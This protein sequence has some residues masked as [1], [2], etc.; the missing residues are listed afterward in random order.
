MGGQFSHGFGRL[1][2]RTGGRLS[3]ERCSNRP[4]QTCSPVLLPT[5]ANLREEGSWL[6]QLSTMRGGDGSS[7]PQFSRMLSY[8]WSSSVARPGAWSPSASMRQPGAVGRSL[9]R[10]ANRETLRHL[11]RRPVG[12][13]RTAVLRT[14]RSH[15]GS[16]VDGDPVRAS[17]LSGLRGARLRSVLVGGGWVVSR[18]WSRDRHPGRRTPGAT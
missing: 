12:G 18:M 2:P 16:G 7:Y 4:W 3:V 13:C 10:P 9:R 17:R 5:G 8:R 1:K 11:V 14:L 15:G 6:L